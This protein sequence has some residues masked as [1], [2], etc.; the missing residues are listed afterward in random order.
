MVGVGE[1][2]RRSSVDAMGHPTNVT[3]TVIPMGTAARDRLAHVLAGD[4][5]ARSDTALLRLPGDTLTLHVADVGPVTLPVR[6]AQAKRLIA[7]A[8]PALFGQGEETLS[9]TSV[10]DTWE[11]TPDQ[12]TLAGASWDAHLSAALA[13]FRD[14]LGLPASS[15]LRAELHSLLVYGKGQFF[16]PHQDSEK[17]DD[18]VA[19]LVVSLPSVHSGGE[20]VVDDGGTERTFRGSRDDLVLVAFYADRRH[21]VRP[22]RSRHSRPDPS[23]PRRQGRLR[24]AAAQ[25]P[26]PPHGHRPNPRRNLRHPAHPGP[27]HQGRP[28]SNR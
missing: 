7:V 1:G 11:L 12:V 9:D 3:R 19:T 27:R 24:H 10:R 20:L 2:L 22:V 13:H 26:T 17:H 14:D 4:Q 8:R 5:A 25:Q 6:A 15:W 23:R 16:L 21:E 28:R 18:M